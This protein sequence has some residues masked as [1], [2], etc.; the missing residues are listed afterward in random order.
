MLIRFFAKAAQN[1]RQ[2]QFGKS[3]LSLF[4]ILNAV[5]DLVVY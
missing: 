1:D 3:S 4:V 2:F 5:K